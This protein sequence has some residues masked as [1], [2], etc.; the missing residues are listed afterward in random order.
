MAE[1]GLVHRLGRAGSRPR[2]QG[3]RGLQRSGRLLG[4]AQNDGKI[5]S[6]EVVLLYPH[7]G[8]LYGFSLLR[9]SAEQFDHLRAD[10][11]FQR[12]NT[13]AGVIVERLGIVPAALG[14]GLGD[15]VGTYQQA[16]GELAG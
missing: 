13:R 12:M 5:E 11:D 14:E 6:F 10:D 2:G 8:D 1:Q 7:G 3:P 9:G 4:R 16:V 15:V